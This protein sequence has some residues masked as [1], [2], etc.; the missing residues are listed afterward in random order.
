MELKGRSEMLKVNQ[1]LISQTETFVKEKFV[2]AEPGHDWWHIDRV[3]R[4]A[5]MLGEQEGA[6]LFIVDLAAL[7]HDVADSKFH[8]GNEEVG[9][10]TAR[11][12]LENLNAESLVID[13]VVNIIKHMSFKN[14]FDEAPPFYSKEFAVVQDADRLDAIGA[15]GIA[16]AFSY[17][18]H[19]NRPFYDPAISPSSGLTKEEY[20]KRAAP[21][22]NHFYEKLLLLKD[23]MNTNAARRLAEERHRFLEVYLEQFYSEWGAT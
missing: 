16:R 3:R 7:L 2:N 17:G 9:P 14:T 12:F 11:A 15:I 13:H 1:H 8:D 10:E 6:D 4:T 22:I 23:K 21:T 5:R 20:K 19:K 18:A